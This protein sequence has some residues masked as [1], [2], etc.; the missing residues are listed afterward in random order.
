[1]YMRVWKCISSAFWRER[2]QIRFW[3]KAVGR[4]SRR[5]WATRDLAIQGAMIT[6]LLAGCAVGP[7]YQPPRPPVI[8]SLS[9]L[10]L[11]RSG[12]GGTEQQIFIQSLDIPGRWWELF[13]CRALDSIIERAVKGNADLDAAR[14]AVRI[15]TANTQ[16]ARGGFYPQIGASIDASA[17][18]PSAA[19]AQASGT[20]PSAYS[21]SSGQLTVS[22]VPDVFGLNKRRVESLAAQA[23]AQHFELVAAYLTLTSKIA[24]AAIEEAS[25]RDEIKSAK[26]SIAIAREVLAFLNRELAV[27]EASRV[28][29]SAQEVALAQ[30]EQARQMLGKRLATNHDLMTALTGHFAG[31]GLAEEFDFACLGLPPKLPLSLPSSI[32]RQRPDVRAAEAQMHAATAEIGVAVANR[33]PQ[34]NLTAD[35]GMS[36]SMIAKLASPS[37]L[38]LFWSIGASAAQTLF[39]GMSGEQKQRAAEAGLERS[40]A[41]YR[42]TVIV[43][44]QNIADVLQAIETDH[45]LFLAAERGMKAAQLNLDLT[46]QLLAQRQASMLQLLSAQQMYAQ[47]RSAHAQA[48]AARRADTVLLF[49]SLGGGWNGHVSPATIERA[50]NRTAA[51]AWVPI[52]KT[53][54]NTH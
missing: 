12:L 49:Q 10:P 15:A 3:A 52:V 40:A 26:L 1:L 18:K 48:R 46:R 36:A 27:S 53:F 28:D 38:L 35:A 13:H 17:Q 54:V 14:A 42:S 43:A 21:L 39:D 45:R 11:S 37:P 34:F 51:V 29:V 20:S 23:E 8:A 31:E 25:I 5:T 9:P 41:L 16:A 32:V 30:F 2:E 50:Q 33:L 4:Y 19:Q 22:F 44:F 47:A 6:V 7:D 24:L